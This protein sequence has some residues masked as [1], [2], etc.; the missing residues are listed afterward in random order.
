MRFQDC[1]VGQ[2]VIVTRQNL[3]NTGK[4]GTI[5]EILNRHVK[6]QLPDREKLLTF[7]PD[8][9]AI[10]V[11]AEAPK[12]PEAPKQPE[13]KAVLAKPAKNDVIFFHDMERVLQFAIL[14]K[15]ATIDDNGN[16]ISKDGKL[17]GEP[18]DYYGFLTA[19]DMVHIT[20]P[21]DHNVWPGWI[22]DMAAGGKFVEVF[23]EDGQKGL[24]FDNQYIYNACWIDLGKTKV[25]GVNPENKPPEKPVFELGTIPEIILK[26]IRNANQKQYENG[27]LAFAIYTE[28]DDFKGYKEHMNVR[29]ACNYGVRINVPDGTNCFAVAQFITKKYFSNVDNKAATEAWCKWVIE[30][31]TFSHAIITETYEQGLKDGVLFNPHLPAN[32]LLNAMIALRFPTEYP[33]VVIRW[34]DLVSKGVEPNVAY[35]FAETQGRNESSGHHKFTNTNTWNKED[36]IRF[37]NKEVGNNPTK[38]LYDEKYNYDK[39]E[40]YYGGGTN[41]QE[42]ALQFLMKRFKGEEKVVK[43]AVLGDQKVVVPALD[44]MIEWATAQIKEQK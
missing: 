41:T 9:I 5:V 30:D 40:V 18:Q 36:L 34:Y 39:I 13:P 16:I 8:S 20:P 28:K 19:G 27:G 1:R 26:Q 21:K 43:N 3:Q 37:V 42:T 38:Y 25:R 15:D 44:Q 22:G 4:V 14:G 29:A 23:E 7:R 10:H 12:A 31:S 17:L 32:Q 35:Y 24:V 11:V 2:Q 33:P 6:V